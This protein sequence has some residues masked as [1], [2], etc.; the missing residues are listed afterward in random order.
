M[1][2]IFCDFVSGK[3]KKST[4]GY[5][6]IAIHQTKSTV[7]FLAEDFPANE[8][9]HMIIIPKR[10]FKNLEDVPSKVLHEMIDHANLASKIIRKHHDGCNI[11]LNNGKSA[12]QYIFHAHFHVIPR[13]SNDGIKIESWKRKKIS[14]EKYKS[15]SK[16]LSE[17]FKHAAKHLYSENRFLL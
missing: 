15:L 12:G 1:E 8:N 6:F 3:R 9:G 13:D 4:K 2:C 10:H 16:K 11:L 17:E 7:S 5:P 14:V